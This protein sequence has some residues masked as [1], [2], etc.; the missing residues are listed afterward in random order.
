MALP[1]IPAQ[2]SWTLLVG[3]YLLFDI[4]LPFPVPSA[5]GCG[6]E[7]TNCI[8]A[9]IISLLAPWEGAHSHYDRSRPSKGKKKS[10]FLSNKLQRQ[11]GRPGRAS[12][13][14]GTRLLI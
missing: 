4:S 8:P 1:E 6:R 10:S 5:V 9:S 11:M 14:T 7:A 3:H 2:P 12:R 13:H